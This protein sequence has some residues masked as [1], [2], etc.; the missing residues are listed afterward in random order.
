MKTKLI[1]PAMFLAL[2]VASINTSSITKQVKVLAQN[3]NYVVNIGDSI[4][5]E[6]RTLIHNDESKVVSGQIIFPDGSSKSGRSFIVAMPGV[7][8]VVYRAY[9]GYEE[10]CETITYSC[11]RKSSDF[12]TS[13]NKNNLPSVGEYSFNNKIA[14]TQGAVL[15]VDTQTTFTYVDEIDFNTFDPNTPFIEYMV[16]TT[17]QG[18]SDLET[19]TIRLTDI[20]DS[21]NYVEITATDSGPIDND[22]QGSYLLAGASNQFKTGYEFFGGKYVLHVNSFG[23]SVGSSF[24]ALPANNPT[25]PTKLYFDYAEK[26]LYASPIMWTTDLKDLITDLDSEDVYGSS[27][28]KG[29]SEG[30]AILSITAKGVINSSAKVV[31]PH[32]GYI[33]LSQMVFEDHSAPDIEIKYNDQS[34]SNLPKATVNRPYNLFDA[35]IKDNYDKNLSYS[36]SVAYNDTEAG[37]KKDISVINNAF[38]PKKAGTYTVTYT[39]RDYSNNVATKTINV[40]AINES[41]SMT[42]SLPQNSMTNT[43]YSTFILPS[44][45]EV[46]INGG[47]GEPQIERRIINARNEEIIIT[48]DTFVP[49]EVGTYNVFYTAIDYIGNVATAKITINALDTT[50]PIF[51][52][53]LVLPRVLIKGHTYTLPSYQGFET[54]NGV[55]NY[56]TSK[57]YV[58]GQELS[59]GKFIAGDNCDVSYKVTGQTGN[60]QYDVNIPIIDGHD[61]TDQAAYFYGDLNAVE[62]EFDV[63]LSTTSDASSLFASVLAY[64]KPSI[65]FAKDPSLNNYQNLLFKF[66]QADNPHV[67]LTFKVRFDGDL[68]YVSMGSNTNE[69]SLGYETREGRNVYSLYFD[70]T[71]CFLTDIN[72]KNI[73]KVYYDDFGNE[74]LGFSGGLYLDISL[75]GVTG[76]SKINILGISNQDL[77]HRGFYL[78]SSNPIIIFNG[79]FVNEQEYNAVAYIPTVSVFDVLGEASA[80]LT[81][82][83]P[84]GSFKLKNVNPIEP[85]SFLLDAFGNYILTYS[86]QDSSG[87]FISYPRKITVFDN[88]APT[89]TVNNNLKN[90]YKINSKITIPSYS[91]SDNL[92]Q[93]TVDVLLLLPNDEE[94]L[95]L[96]DT[97]GEVTSYLTGDSPL[98]NSSFKV[99]SKTFRAEQYGTYKLRFVAYD[100][101]FNKTVYE[102]T[103]MV[104]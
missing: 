69:Y 44:I 38:T 89:L 15:N 23:C 39:A 86:V 73:A 61:S 90:S 50:E 104:K 82:K 31:L 59:D 71:G 52:G 33:D 36:V 95:L 11:Y 65:S 88:V 47:S 32:V 7:Y 64:D 53:D 24:R 48:G 16:D 34:S 94:R 26:K 2:A 10:E 54:I 74:F 51:I 41:Q 63:A 97:N 96:R 14:S 102:I 5:I 100:D 27:I 43:V 42:I 28:W 19:L 30:K 81:V 20:N 8:Q 62:N 12:F 75:T 17:K 22:G 3:E 87:N 103:F 85:Q 25:K 101:A 76:E 46:E 55:A 37:K 60:G 29:F 21:S 98:Y 18:E 56:L 99:D 92:G 49:T 1:I 70:N 77:G 6:D 79:I 93:Y 13:S 72:Y 4:D 66:S 35:T 45:D 91:I 84:D 68:A 80:T 78:D 67:S 40:V 9:F 83:A 57:V 58:N